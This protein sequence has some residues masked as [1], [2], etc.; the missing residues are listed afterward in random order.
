MGCEVDAASLQAQGDGEQWRAASTSWL[1]HEAPRD[2]PEAAIR[3]W[4][5]DLG[6]LGLDVDTA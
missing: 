5:V 4:V 2:Q 6:C 1:A 3:A